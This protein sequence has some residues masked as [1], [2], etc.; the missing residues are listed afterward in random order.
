MKKILLSVFLLA[1]VIHQTTIAQLPDLPSGGATTYD[2]RV[3]PAGSY[4]IAMDNTNQGNGTIFNMKAYGLIVYLLNNNA[5]IKWIIKPGKVKDGIDFS[6]NANRIVPTVGTASNFDF[7]AGPFVIFAS[8]TAG[9]AALANTYNGVPNN[10]TDVNVYK[11][12]ADV[13]VDVRYDLTGFKPKAAILN[14]MVP[15]Q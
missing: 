7:R 15:M 12:N 10:G 14:M 4:V 9:I 6:V 3:L 2:V 11:T 1:I 13:V 8:D 5:R